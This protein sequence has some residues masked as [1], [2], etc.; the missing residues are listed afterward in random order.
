[1]IS[2]RTDL[3]GVDWE[4]LKQDLIADDFHNG[5]TT[6]Q[7]RLSFENSTHVA[8]GFDGMRCIANG[9]LL[10]DGV[11]NAYVIDVWTHSGYRRRGIARKIMQL[12]LGAVP[13]QHVYLQTDDAV[14]FY[15]SLGF[16]PQPQGMSLVVGEYLGNATR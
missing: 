11:G 6:P 13:G 15:E 1:M 7:L 14:A 2:F 9:R 16:A 3:E 10:S 4:A 8:M 5:R 12:L